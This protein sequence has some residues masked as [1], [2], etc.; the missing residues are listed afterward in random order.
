MLALVAQHV[1]PREVLFRAG[2]TEKSVCHLLLEHIA[3]TSLRFSEAG[4]QRG[5]GFSV[6]AR[7]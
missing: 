1:G 5:L 2:A 4:G 6:A 3:Y 7:L